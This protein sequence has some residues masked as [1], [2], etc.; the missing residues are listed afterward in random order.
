[1]SRKTFFFFL[2]PVT[3]NYLTEY[4]QTDQ[5]SPP[6]INS[7]LST[8]IFKSITSALY[9]IKKKK[10]IDFFANQIN[11]MKSMAKKKKSAISHLNIKS[12]IHKN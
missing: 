1:M 7:K 11:G 3:I 5:K 8:L 6:H 2:I 9:Y 12:N 4:I 10:L